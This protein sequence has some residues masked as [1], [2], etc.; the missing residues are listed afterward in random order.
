MQHIPTTTR[1]KILI[2]DDEPFNVDYLEQ[3]LE[4]LEYD[5]IAASNGQEALNLVAT[6][7]PDVILLDVQ[8][9]IMNGFQTLTILKA[10]A[11]TRD[12]P[13]IIIS[14]AH[15]LENV[16]KGIEMGAEDYLPKPFDPV[17]LRA[18]IAASLAKKQW[19]D[20]ERTYLQQIEAEKR[21]ADELLQVILPEPIIAELKET[22]QFQPR[23]FD[24]VAIMFIDVVGFT[25]Y[26]EAHDPH[27]VVENLQHMVAAYE[28]VAV[29]YKMQKIKT[30]GDAFMVVAGL[31]E[32]VENPVFTCVQSGWEMIEIAQNLPD[33]WQVRV[34]IHI[35]PIIGAIVGHRQYLFDIWGDPV[36]TA[37]RVESHGAVN[38]VNLS[39]HAWQ[40]VTHLCSGTSLGIINVKGK[41]SM[42]LF[43][44]TP[45]PKN[46]V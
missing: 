4:D 36:N 15:D 13:V 34:G 32:S 23:H 38:A 12:I 43:K 18:R 5:T 33:P 9:P 25:P 17:L 2:V 35:G 7:P 45:T 3:E 24:N 22:N 21:R 11:H 26:S 37:Q 16:V 46:E 28:E 19:H 39:K 8:M 14:A 1:P 31:F 6:D 42:E 40:Q 29:Q 10:D 20:R 41:G 27:H 30:S 44:V